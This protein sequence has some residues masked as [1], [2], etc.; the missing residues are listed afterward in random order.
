MKLQPAGVKGL[1]YRWSLAACKQAA[2]EANYCYLLV[3]GIF[4][5]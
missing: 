1:R 2:D 4:T 3:S 5:A